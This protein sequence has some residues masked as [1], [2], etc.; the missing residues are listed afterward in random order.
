MKKEQLLAIGVSNSAVTEMHRLA[1]E[2]EGRS[3]ERQFMDVIAIAQVTPA[4]MSS[5]SPLSATAWL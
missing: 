2:V 5:S 1:A 4:R 3:T